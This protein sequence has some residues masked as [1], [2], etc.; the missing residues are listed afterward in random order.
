[1]LSIF[2]HWDTE[3]VVAKLRQEEAIESVG[4]AHSSAAYCNDQT[5]NLA[6]YSKAVY[7]HYKPELKEGT[8][9][10]DSSYSE[11]KSVVVSRDLGYKIGDPIK[12]KI[13]N[14]N[15]VKGIVAGVLKEPT[16]YLYPQG[17]AS[18]QYF[19]A[20]RIIDQR[21]VVIMREEDCPVK[22]TSSI[23][24]GAGIPDI[25]FVYFRQSMETEVDKV[26]RKYGRYGEFAMMDDLTRNYDNNT[27][28]MIGGGILFFITFFFLA[29]TSAFSTNI[30]QQTYNHRRFTIYYLLGMKKSQ[31]LIV[32]IS[33]II[34]LEVIVMGL[35]VLSGK[36]GF[37]MLEW[38][39][40]ERIVLFYTI[41][42]FTTMFVFL[43]V[44]IGFWKKM[45]KL[46]I[47]QSLIDLQHGE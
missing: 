5:C 19:S 43:S 26:M 1:M 45:I 46:D 32:E 18:P 47:S 40:H 20:D 6:V 30:I 8:W 11:I 9:L 21:S 13:D 16:Q 15:I 14:K 35:I 29:V 10:T 25:V 27:R 39:T 33:R 17:G 22:P 37:L 24:K 2:S 34:I 23:P 3:E 12:I 28:Q 41:A 7:E 42:F 31:M 36:Y 38:M 4:Y 44:S